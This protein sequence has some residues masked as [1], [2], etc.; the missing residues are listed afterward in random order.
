MSVRRLRSESVFLYFLFGGEIQRTEQSMFV[1]LVRFGITT[2]NLKYVTHW[3]TRSRIIE[4]KSSLCILCQ[5]VQ[6]VSNFDKLRVIAGSFT[7]C[8]V[9]CVFKTEHLSSQGSNTWPGEMSIGFQVL[10]DITGMFFGQTTLHDLY[11]LILLTISFHWTFTCVAY[12]SGDVF[13]CLWESVPRFTYL[14]CKKCMNVLVIVVFEACPSHPC[15]VII[16]MDFPQSQLQKCD[17][18]WGF[19][20][21]FEMIRVSSR[22]VRTLMITV[23]LRDHSSRFCSWEHY[24]L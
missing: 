14:I 22:F 24:I 2:W 17:Y 21:G 6:T 11:S 10:L 13:C 15:F 1:M 20:T 8:S 19:W 23:F 7:D 4:R 3:R 5:V 16:A 9:A 18:G 12:F